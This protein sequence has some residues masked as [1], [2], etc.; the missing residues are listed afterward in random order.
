MRILGDGTNAKRH[1]KAKQTN[2]FRKKVTKT[3]S[4]FTIFERARNWAGAG[5]GAGVG[6][7]A[8]GGA[9][10]G[11]GAGAGTGHP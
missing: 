10:A 3:L 2:A 9:G 4:V 5:A 11:I 1:P 8:G 6:A 7:R